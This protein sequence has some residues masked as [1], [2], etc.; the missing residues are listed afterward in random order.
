MIS[1]LEHQDCGE[2]LKCWPS[3]GEFQVAQVAHRKKPI[4]EGRN[5]ENWNNLMNVRS[6][7]KEA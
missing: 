5:L 1:R 3:C 7:I 2:D 6:E 4:V